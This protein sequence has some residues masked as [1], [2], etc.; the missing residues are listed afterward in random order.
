MRVISSILFL[1]VSANAQTI[2][3]TTIYAKADFDAKCAQA[4]AQYLTGNQVCA[5][6]TG[7]VS[8]TTGQL[9][10]ERFCGSP[11]MGQMKAMYD[12]T[13]TCML[14]YRSKLEADLQRDGVANVTALADSL[15][16]GAKVIS[17]LTDY[18]CVRNE[19]DEY[20]MPKYT[21]FS[22]DISATVGTT[23]NSTTCY[24]YANLGCC[25][26]ALDIFA[27]EGTPQSSTLSGLI[28]RMCPSLA[29]VYPPTC[30]NYG[31]KA[32]ALIVT[33]PLNGLVCAAFN[34][35]SDQL[36]ADYQAALQA[37]LAAGGLNSSYTVIK[38]VS[39]VN[40]VCTATVVVRAENDDVTR[41]LKTAAST[42]NTAA[43]TQSNQ[44]LTAA[45]ET[46]TGNVTFG[47]AMVS[48]AT[49]SGQS[50]NSPSSPSSAAFAAPGVLLGAIV[51]TISL[52]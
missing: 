42:A 1:V 49:V 23:G 6:Q 4:S 48:E 36:K 5:Q 9:D 18:M 37:D 14:G 12:A 16:A 32:L 13:S 20:C 41:S 25:L 15:M 11:C 7:M 30:L 38:S 24:A 34:R 19:R 2:S 51:L 8:T 45:P 47:A 27:P 46:F 39:E 17:R 29:N 43:L 28:V 50:V 26:R 35:Q 52:A 31:Q 21:Q 3:N 10:L 22:K 40:G 33:M 44:V